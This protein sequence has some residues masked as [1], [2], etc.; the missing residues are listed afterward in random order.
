LGFFNDLALRYGKFSNLN[1]YLCFLKIAFYGLN[2]PFVIHIEKSDV[3]LG[4]IKIDKKHVKGHF[5]PILT[6]KKQFE[7]SRLTAF[8]H[9]KI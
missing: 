5:C 2:L 6:L 4:K 7:G 1:G 3:A 8:F 9:P